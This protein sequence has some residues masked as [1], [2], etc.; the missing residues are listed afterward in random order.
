[1]LL[2]FSVKLQAQTFPSNDGEQIRYSAYI[3]MPKAYLSGICILQHD[4]DVVNGC[5]FNEFGVTTLDFTY[6]LQKQKIKLHDVLPMM[7]KWFIRRVL[8][9]D[10]RQLMQRLQQGETQYKNERQHITYQLTPIHETE[11]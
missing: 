9:K 10:L 11:E 3:E 1:L 2:G 4:G 8:K 5:L 6:C 7:D